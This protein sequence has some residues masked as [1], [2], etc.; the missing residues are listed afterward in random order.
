MILP[1]YHNNEH[2]RRSVS[3]IGILLGFLLVMSVL[4]GRT[5]AQD[6]KRDLTSLNIEDLMNIEI[7]SSAKKA[8]SLRLTASA[9]YVITQDDIRRSGATSIPELLR[10]APGLHVG[11]LDNSTWAISSRGF[12]GRFANKLLVLIDGRS[13]YSPLFSGVHWDVQDLLLEDVERIEII[14]G[15]GAALWGANAVN[16]VINVITKHSSKTRGGFVA[17][18]TSTTEPAVSSVR[19][20]G[21]IGSIGSYRVYGKYFNRENFTDLAG[22]LT[23]NNW[24]ALR[25]GFRID[26]SATDSDSLNIQG[27][28]YRG[29]AGK[30]LESATL[31]PPFSSPV[32]YNNRMRGGNL[33]ARWNRTLSDRSATELKVYYDKSER[34]ELFGREQ[35]NTLDLDFQHRLPWDSRQDIVWGAGFRINRDHLAGNFP[36]SLDPPSR[37]EHVFNAFLQDEIT[38]VKNVLRVTLGAKFEDTNHTDPTVL[39]NARVL[40]TPD[41]R[42]TIWGAV[43]HAHRNPARSDRD[44]NVTVRIFPGPSGI[45]N[46]VTVLGDKNAP[47]EE[48]TAYEGGYRLQSGRAL[49]EVAAY[50]NRY[51]NLVTF[52]PG[53]PFFETSPVPHITL[54][55][56]FSNLRSA[57]TFGIETNG[58]W[59]VTNRWRL[60]GG[61]TWYKAVTRTDPSSQDRFANQEQGNNPGHQFSLRSYLQLPKNFE[62][63]ASA[64][65]ASKL[66]NLAVP[67]HTRFDFRLGW[68]PSETLAFSFGAKDVVNATHRELRGQVT[69]SNP[70]AIPR[71]VY[72]KI[73]WSF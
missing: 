30:I 50:Y 57:D 33:L 8:E 27:D 68:R 22:R 44:A 52:E 42:Q 7:V 36:F 58:N 46:F 28:I 13:V 51:G 1:D 17:V 12:N 10:M 37:T 59:A 45:L 60:S 40:W 41:N 67:A 23:S 49:L 48:L 64:Y 43:A 62:L 73:A 24:D 20:G 16:G 34:T 15:P 3:A 72:G 6:D 55:V 21:S 11:R 66:P 70:S 4:P 25:G 18:S 32:Y 14:R 39:P 54:P 26:L 65:Y 63:D 9:A 71:E 29:D 38:I 69:E 53:I 2:R 5:S 56:R 35:V 47:P 19:Y 61:F 31:T